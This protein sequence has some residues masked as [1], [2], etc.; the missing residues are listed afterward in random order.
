M[1][2]DRFND[3]ELLKAAGIRHRGEVCR[4][5][6]THRS[7]GRE[8]GLMLTIQESG[9]CGTSVIEWRDAESLSDDCV[10]LELLA[11]LNAAALQDAG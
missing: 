6:R 7:G 9:L 3:G 2:L 8:I 1:A 11:K 10:L 5:E 4:Y